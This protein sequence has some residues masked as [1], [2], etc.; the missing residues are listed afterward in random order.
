MTTL[1][2]SNLSYR[3]TAGELARAFEPYGKVMESR[4]LTRGR[5]R[6]LRSRGCGFVN[7]ELPQEAQ[8]ALNESKPIMLRDRE[9][10]VKLRDEKVPVNDTV[11]IANLGSN[12]TREVLMRFFAGFDPVDASVV[13]TRESDKRKGFGY[14]KVGSEEKRDAAIE[15]LNDRELDGEHVVVVTARRGFLP[16]EEVEARKVRREERIRKR[17]SGVTA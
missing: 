15:A 16:A 8:A 2:V 5:G 10:H 3:L 9:A 13:Y 1:Y 12:V 11:F 4:I 6:G 17:V 14:V 7:F